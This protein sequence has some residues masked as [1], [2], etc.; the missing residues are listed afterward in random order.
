MKIRALSVFESVI[1]HCHAVDLANPCRPTLEVEA[2]V[3]EGDVD[4]GPLYLPL[5]EYLV[6]V[7]SDAGRPCLAELRR[8]GRIVEV[9]GVPHLSFPTWTPL[10]L[11]QR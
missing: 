9:Q 1:Y 6:M 10:E 3:R 8:K 5:A 2:V 7:G 4:A 11:E